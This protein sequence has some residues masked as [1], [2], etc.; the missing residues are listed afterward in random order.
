MRP[1]PALQKGEDLFRLLVE[2]VSDNGLFMLDPDGYVRSW[3][4]GAERLEGYRADEIVGKH[5]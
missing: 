4:L 5:F 3:N 2:S 1:D